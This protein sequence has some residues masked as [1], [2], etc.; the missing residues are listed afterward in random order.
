MPALIQLRHFSAASAVRPRA[1]RRVLACAL[2]AAILACAGAAYAGP[3]V[4]TEER[5]DEAKAQPVVVAGKGSWVVVP[6]PVANPTIGNGLQAAVLY[7][8]PKAADDVGSP[9]ATS[10]AVAMATDTG[11]RLLGVFHDGS[12]AADRYRVSAFAGAATFNLKFYGIGENAILADHPLTYRMSGAIAQVRGEARLPATQHWFAG[13]TYQFL[14]STLTFQTSQL[15]PG[16]ADL[17]VD[18]KSVGVGPHVTFDSRDSNYYP[19]QGQYFRA[20]WLD[21]GSRW[22][23][24]F[25]FDKVDVFYNQYLP[26]GTLSVLALRG[27]LQSASQSTPFFALPTLD[28]RGFS[29]DRY[30]DNHT[31]SLSAEFRH[32]LAPRWGVVGYAEAGRFAPSL[33]ALADGR[34]IKTVGAG[35]RWQV[36]SGRDMNLGLDFAASSDDRA[37]FIQIG[38]RF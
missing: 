15:A 8:H 28:M 4:N 20:R 38:E 19:Q 13:V 23:G 22:G 30:R 7:L 33:H 35:V 34:T 14:Q 3:E 27:R 24:D 26:M 17:P 9:G 25:D 21:Y 31:L 10:G 32:K 6:I 1:H 36:T 18:F 11:A 16:L 12:F 29:Q 37:V 5:V 2:S